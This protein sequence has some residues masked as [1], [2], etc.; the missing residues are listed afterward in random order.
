MKAPF[1][2]RAAPSRRFGS[3]HVDLVGPLPESKGKKYLLTVIDRFARWIEAIPLADITA[4]SCVEGLLH[5]WIAR[6]RVPDDLVADRGAQ[7]TS[8]LWWQ[9]HDLFGISCSNTT[10]Y[11]PQANGMIERIHRQLKAALMA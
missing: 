11:H 6:Y 2:R 8:A 4:D 9:V 5:G 10:A 3:I 7:F 1:K